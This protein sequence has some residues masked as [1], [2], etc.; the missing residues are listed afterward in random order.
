MIELYDVGRVITGPFKEGYEFI[1]EHGDRYIK[2]KE[3]LERI[4]AFHRDRGKISQ[5][6]FNLL[7]YVWVEAIYNNE[8]YVNPRELV[9]PDVKPRFEKVRSRGDKV[10]LHTSG[11]RELI[12]ILLKNECEYDEV[13]VGEETGDKNHPET[14]ARIWEYTKGKI[15]AFYDD[16]PSVLHAAHEG[17]QMAAAKPRLYLVD[18]LGTVDEEKVR[19][20]ES[21]G[22]VKI[23]S[24]NGI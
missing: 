10:I 24:L 12:D 17:F 20:L 11:S 19:E 9:Y 7:N 2:D 4:R 1:V 14:F 6:D 8:L 23:T 16:K 5:E 13:L 3:A 22:V 18:R 21:K 15:L